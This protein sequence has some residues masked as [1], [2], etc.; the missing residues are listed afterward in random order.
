M[1]YII[2]TIIGAII[3]SLAIVLNSFLTAK[4]TKEREQREYLRHRL[5]VEISNLDEIYQE[6]IHSID[7]LIRGKGSA[8]ES[9]LEKYYKLA[10]QIRLKSTQSIYDSFNKL[11]SDIVNMA[12]NIPP[13][14]EEFI[15]KFENDDDR[16][17][18]LEKRKKAEKSRE[19]EATK[20]INELYKDL[21][22]LT[23]DMRAHLE[24]KGM[25]VISTN[26][27]KGG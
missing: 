25:S 26:I 5:D 12:K 8:S 7:K 2:G 13:L 14:P 23:R 16:R 22:K 4:I 9:E 27:A 20:Y 18:R 11:R 10:I 19:K 6:A 17:Y 15:P 1:E 3:T 24:E 21:D